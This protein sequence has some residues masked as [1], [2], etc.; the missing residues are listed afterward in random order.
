MIPFTLVTEEYELYYGNASTYIEK[1]QRQSEA[2]R[3]LLVG[4]EVYGR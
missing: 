1:F 2:D 3:C 4:A